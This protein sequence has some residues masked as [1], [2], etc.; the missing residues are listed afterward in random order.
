VPLAGDPDGLADPQVMGAGLPRVDRERELAT[1]GPLVQG[2][3]IVGGE[4]ALAPD[5][6]PFVVAARH[7][8][9]RLVPPDRPLEGRRLARRPDDGQVGVRVLQAV[10]RDRDLAIADRVRAL[11]EG[12][13]PLRDAVGPGPLGREEL[14]V[15]PAAEAVQRV[16]PANFQL[17]VVPASAEHHADG[18]GGAVGAREAVRRRDVLHAFDA[19]DHLAVAAVAGGVGDGL[20]AGFVE[21]VG[22]TETGSCPV[23]WRRRAMLALTRRSVKAAEP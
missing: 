6:E 18:V 14:H 2:V 7:G 17:Q 4:R 13:R 10:D 16:E 20:A 9:L 5:R 23:A 19:G 12:V 22:D 15:R 11:E 3:P 1:A 8:V 21:P